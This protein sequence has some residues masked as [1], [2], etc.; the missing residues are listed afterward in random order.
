[1]SANSDNYQPAFFLRRIARIASTVTRIF[2]AVGF[3]ASTALAIVHVHSLPRYLALALLV[4]APAYAGRLLVQATE[5]YFKRGRLT[6]AERRLRRLYVASVGL[7]GLWIAAGFAFWWWESAFCELLVVLVIWTLATWN[8]CAIA[9]TLPDTDCRGGTEALRGFAW[10]RRARDVMGH[11]GLLHDALARLDG[12]TSTDA[13]SSFFDRLSVVLLAIAVALVPFAGAEGAEYVERMSSHTRRLTAHVG[14]GHRHRRD[15]HEP[16]GGGGRPGGGTSTT[17]GAGTTPTVAAEPEPSFEEQ[18]PGA[19]RSLTGGTSAVEVVDIAESM[20]RLW[21]HEGATQ[22]GCPGRAHPVPH[23]QGVWYAEGTCGTSLRTLV[24][25]VRGGG[26]TIQYQQAAAFGLQLAREGRLMY[27]S[28]R[29]S[30]DGGD[31]YLFETPEGRVALSRARS[32]LGRT[33]TRP[34]ARWCERLSSTNVPY[35]KTPPEVTR[36]WRAVEEVFKVSWPVQMSSS[37]HGE[38]Y[39][40]VSATPTPQVVATAVCTAPDACTAWA[41]EGALP[42]VSQAPV[43]VEE[44]Q[45]IAEHAEGSP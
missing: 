36:I 41:T 26:A 19:L 3:L 30:L 32:A 18:C 6:Q 16:P 17:P 2:S 29:G 20:L 39:R 38:V 37:R 40:F 5:R 42:A 22:A 28:D 25:Y 34:T 21:K 10:F 13:T 24:V 45:W 23:Q 27:A 9:E 43:T 14:H 1:M 11:S 15:R 8:A 33:T 35:E 12:V 4:T 44:M 31:L 7:L